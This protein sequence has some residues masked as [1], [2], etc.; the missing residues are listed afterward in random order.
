MNFVI[1]LYCCSSITT[2]CKYEIVYFD[3]SFYTFRILHRLILLYLLDLYFLF[4]FIL[5]YH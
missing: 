3:Y 5:M 2:E 1:N 4:Q